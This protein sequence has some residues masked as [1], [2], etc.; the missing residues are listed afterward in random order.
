MALITKK[1]SSF[2]LTVGLSL[3]LLVSSSPVFAAI[4]TIGGKWASNTKTLYVGGGLV[5]WSAGAAKWKNATNFKVTASSGTSTSYY[6]YDVNLAS[7]TWDAICSV[8]LN[9]G[10][11]TKATLR[12]NTYFTNQSRYTAAIKNGVTAHEIGHSLGLDHTKSDQSPASIMYPYTF[13]GNNPS[14]RS[15][16]PSADDIATVNSL[17]PSV[18][19]TAAD[20]HDNTAGEIIHLS[21]SW[22]TYYEDEEALSKAADL[23]VRGQV[24]KEKG[25]KFKKDEHFTYKTEV[26]L[27]ASEVLKGDASLNGKDIIVSQMGGTDGKNKV[28]GEY[29]TLL[30]TNQE[31]VLFLLQAEDGTYNLINEDDSIFLLNKYGEFGNIASEQD[32]NMSKIS[33]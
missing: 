14:V 11:I 33:N 32:L 20:S 12:M 25:S 2:L 18:P 7:E 28:I 17:Y 5:A 19:F 31:V 13:N 24:S 23:V 9:A 4:P 27:T 1:R 10:T 21:P 6:A 16:S 22:A 30:K 15:L 8:V 29:T 26:A 3:S